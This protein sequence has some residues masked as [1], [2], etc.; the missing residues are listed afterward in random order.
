MESFLRD[1]VSLALDSIPDGTDTMP[2]MRQESNGSVRVDNNGCE[3]F[4][5]R[6]ERF[7]AQ[8]FHE[9]RE[10]DGGIPMGG[11]NQEKYRNMEYLIKMHTE[12]KWATETDKLY[13]TEMTGCIP[14]QNE[15]LNMVM[16]G[17]VLCG[18]IV[19]EDGCVSNQ[20]INKAATSLTADEY[21]T[22]LEEFGKVMFWSQRNEEKQ[23]DPHK[24]FEVKEEDWVD[25]QPEY[26]P[27]F[28]KY[29]LKESVTT[30]MEEGATIFAMC[31]DP[32]CLLM[33]GVV[34]QGCSSGVLPQEI[35]AAAMDYLTKRNIYQHD[36]LNFGNTDICQMCMEQNCLKTD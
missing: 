36:D 31:D 8:G 24:E 13:T 34:L 15:L 14:T 26:L 19:C 12:E 25:F 9:S 16:K 22:I 27:P 20:D 4:E 1:S 6:D 33:S 3:M 2:G 29:K 7:V 11:G 10:E 21:T 5:V 35:T 23:T 28:G 18:R 30:E 17:Y 32:T